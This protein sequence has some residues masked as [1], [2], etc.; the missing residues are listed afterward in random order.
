MVIMVDLVFEE[1]QV[2]KMEVY[3]AFNDVIDHKE[4]LVLRLYSY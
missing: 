1:D 4:D 3:F 2:A